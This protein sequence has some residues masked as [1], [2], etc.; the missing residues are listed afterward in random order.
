[1]I[2]EINN[3]ESSQTN[4]PFFIRLEIEE[5]FAILKYAFFLSIHCTSLR[6]VILK[7]TGLNVCK[8]RASLTMDLRQIQQMPAFKSLIINKAQRAHQYMAT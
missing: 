8:H 2:E 6:K 3:T 5:A 1:M 7:S 4:T